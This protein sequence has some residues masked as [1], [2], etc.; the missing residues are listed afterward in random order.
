MT[1]SSDGKFGSGPPTIT[2]T[3]GPA[4]VSDSALLAS[5]SSDRAAELLAM[6]AMFSSGGDRLAAIALLHTAATRLENQ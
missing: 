5:G 4:D 2:V 6:I 3:P 1:R